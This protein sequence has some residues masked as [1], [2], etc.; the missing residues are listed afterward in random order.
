MPRRSR[1]V[2][3]WGQ[4]YAITMAVLTVVALVAA[5]VFA[6]D[7]VPFL[8]LLTVFV[9]FGFIASSILAWTGFAMVYRVSP[10]LWFS[11]QTYR[12]LAL[13]PE[14][15]AEGRDARA[16]FTGLS[17]GLALL[18]TAWAMSGW[19]SAVLVAAIAAAA[20]VAY[21]R[22]HRAASARSARP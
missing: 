8:Q 9:G 3:L 21:A 2:Q 4:A 17:F 13:R 7:F 6:L 12:D 18:G 20:V 1:D 15:R 10:T 14:L 11:S 5:Q 19:A 22:G 16:L